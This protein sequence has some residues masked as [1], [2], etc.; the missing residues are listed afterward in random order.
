MKKGIIVL[1]IAVLVAGFAFAGKF[2]GSAAIEF[3]VDLNAQEWGF[4]NITK[5]KYSFNF[6]LDTTKVAI[7]EE[8]QTDVWAE[9]AAEATA[10]VKL[11]NGALGTNVVVDPKYTAKITVANIHV[12]DITFGILNAGTA[13]NFASSYYDDDDDGDPD[14]DTVQGGSKLVAGFTVSY[15]DWFG[16][17]G[18]E[19]SWATDPATYKVFAHVAT[20]DF[21][22]AEDA[23]S[24]K[25]GVY[26]FV[27]D[28][29]TTNKTYFGGAA[30][31]DYTSDKFDAGAAADLQYGVAAEKFLYEA[32]AYADLKFVENWPISINVY[33]TPGAL[34]GIAAYAG[35]YAESLKL[36]A[37]VSTSGSVDFNEDTKLGIGAYVEA[38]DA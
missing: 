16:G 35:D 30:K 25:A 11:S 13:V 6:E 19:G 23:V 34:T 10:F 38:R 14:F 4:A 27:T 12:G 32:S 8:H 33:A 26:A 1:L 3:E 36:D 28:K 37:K 5:G 31:A 9:L 21:K 18:A 22:F 2:T 29:D 17:F 24:V 20:P 15:K 7:G